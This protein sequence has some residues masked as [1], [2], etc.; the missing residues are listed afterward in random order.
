VSD[1]DDD[2][3]SASGHIVRFIGGKKVVFDDEGFLMDANAWDETVAQT[4]AAEM[5]LTE[6]SDAHWRVIRFLRDYYSRWGK[7]PMSREIRKGSNLS[8]MEIEK[9]FPEG[10]K[11][12]ARRVSGLPNPRG[13]V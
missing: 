1:R 8:M 5:G 3:V 2:H 9:L 6:L 12:G 13:C 11:R 10:V 7:S 4:L